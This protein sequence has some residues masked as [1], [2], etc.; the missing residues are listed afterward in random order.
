MIIFI[1]FPISFL[2]LYRCLI[3]FSHKEKKR[4]PCF[5]LLIIKV[6]I[7]SENFHSTDSLFLNKVHPSK[8]PCFINGE[9]KTKRCRKS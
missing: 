6:F 4:K 8:F 9:K 5:K 1:H 2:P 3:I 7:P